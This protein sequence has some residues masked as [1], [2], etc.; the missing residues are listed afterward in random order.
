MSPKIECAVMCRS[1]GQTNEP[2]IDF[3]KEQNEKLARPLQNDIYFYAITII[4]SSDDHRFDIA[5][6]RLNARLSR[7]QRATIA[8]K[9]VSFWG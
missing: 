1:K 5:G 9:A 8:M 3:A 6:K 7:G 2:D 4:N